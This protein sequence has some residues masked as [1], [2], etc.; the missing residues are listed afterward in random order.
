[1]FA[2]RKLLALVAQHVECGQDFTAC[3]SRRNHAVNIATLGC[4]IGVEQAFFVVGFECG[5]FFGCGAPLQDGRCLPGTHHGKFGC[6]P[7]QAHVVAHALAVHHDVGAAITFTQNHTHSWHSGAPI[8]KHQLGAV[9]NHAAP[10][11]VFAGVKTR[12]VNQGHDRQVECVAKRHEARRFLRCLNVERARQSQ[13]LV[14]HNAH[15]APADGGQRGDHIVGPAGA[16]FKVRAV[17]DDRLNYMPHV[18]AAGG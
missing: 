13:R 14:G 2:A 15:R 4:H 7:G 10:F 6:W 16:Q 1:M 9:A 12:R 17:V 8:G 5:A 3:F 11:Q 18:V